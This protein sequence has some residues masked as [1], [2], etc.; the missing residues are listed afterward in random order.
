MKIMKCYNYKDKPLHVFGIPFFEERGVPERLPKEILEQVPSLE[1]LGKRATG[2]RVAFRT[3]S[4][5]ITVKIRL[6]TLSVDRGMSIYACQ[7]AHILAGDR[8]NLRFPGLV[9]P[10]DY[11]TT[12]FE[13]TFEKDGTMEDI[14]IYLPRNEQIEDVNVFVEEDATVTEP[15][16]YRYKPILFYGSSITEGGCCC[17]P[18]NAYN[19]IISNR[20]DVDFYNFG[21]SGSAKGETVLADY[22]STIDMSIFVYDYDHNAPD[23]NFLRAMHKPFFDII[24]K[25]KPNLPIVIMTMP[26]ERYDEENTER[27]NVIKATYEAAKASGDKNVYFIDGETFFGENERYMCSID[28]IHPNDLGFAR[29]ADVITPV[30]REIL[31]KNN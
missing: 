18:F 23:A 6:K 7:S 21:F 31:E 15:T 14:T 9:F 16:P 11:D 1:F 10:P 25:N 4:K 29:M 19:A 24:R 3:N 22:I 17:N 2:A 26:K 20:L 12:E 30:I 13:G 28:G 5:K 8:S 27:R